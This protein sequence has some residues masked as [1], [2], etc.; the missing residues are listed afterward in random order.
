MATAALSTARAGRFVGS[1][2]AATPRRLAASAAGPRRLVCSRATQL[3]EAK[4]SAKHEKSEKVSKHEEEE[5][6]FE[7]DD[8]GLSPQQ[9]ET[10][11]SVLCEETDIAEVELK[12][13]GFRMRVRRSLTGA[14]PAAAA[15]APVAAAPAPAPP[16]AAPTQWAQAQSASLS[17]AESVDEDEGLLDVTAN[18]VGILRRGRYMKGKQVGKGNMVQPGD[19]VKKGQTLAY[20][21]QLGTHWP[22]E[23]PQAGE[24]VEFLVDEG[25]PVEYKEP[26]LVISPFFGVPSTGYPA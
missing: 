23:S 17:S 12:M 7:G 5:E 11:L 1:R 2:Q 16:A 3:T 26:V 9:V 18:K 19:Q 21:E 4:N 24:V 13:G 10:L 22:L 25:S 15:P 20:I 8:D 6:E 14:T